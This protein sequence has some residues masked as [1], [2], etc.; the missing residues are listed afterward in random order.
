MAVEQLPAVE[1]I[2]SAILVVRGQRVMLN[3]DLARLYTATTSRLNEQVRR[4]RSGTLTTHDAAILKLLADIR[5]LTQFPE[6]VRRGIGFTA[7]WPKR[8]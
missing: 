2:E 4:N 7:E 1:A 5:R 3:A 8:V 6:P